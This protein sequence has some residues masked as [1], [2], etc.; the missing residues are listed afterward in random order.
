MKKGIIKKMT[1]DLR[2]DIL[3]KRETK[4]KT[5]YPITVQRIIKN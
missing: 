2:K 5:L 4:L 1:K 3:R